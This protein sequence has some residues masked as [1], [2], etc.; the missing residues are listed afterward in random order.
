M[1]ALQ[2]TISAQKDEK[3]KEIKKTY[4][5]SFLKFKS[6]FNSHYSTSAIIYYFLVRISPITEEHVKFQGGQFDKIERMFFGPDNFLKIIDY[7]K[8]NRKLI[9]DMFY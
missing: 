1:R 2:L 5:K 6:H 4:D 3:R 8:D 9:P 7:L